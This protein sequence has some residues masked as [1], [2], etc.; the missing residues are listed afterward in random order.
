MHI[1][2]PEYDPAGLA[3]GDTIYLKAHTVKHI[4]VEG[5]AVQARWDSQGNWQALTIE[6]VVCEHHTDI[7][8]PEFPGLKLPNGELLMGACDCDS[9]I[10][11]AIQAQTPAQLGTRTT[12]STSLHRT[13]SS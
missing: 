4:D 13:L 11:T 8:G 10:H 5:T 12:K 2:E 1:S 3:S 6:N 9:S 7:T